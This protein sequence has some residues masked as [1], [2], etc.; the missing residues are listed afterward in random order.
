L[1]VKDQNHIGIQTVPQHDIALQLDHA[2]E[3]VITLMATTP[4]L[5]AQFGYKMAAVMQGKPYRVVQTSKGLDIPWGSEYVLE[6]RILGRQRQPERPFGEF[7]GYYSGCH[8]YLL[9]EIDRVSHRKDPIYPR[10]IL[11]LMWAGHD[12]QCAGL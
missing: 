4:M 2:E 5:Y 8:K 1:Q 10:K 7:P 6:G 12:N 11:I 3:P 9:I